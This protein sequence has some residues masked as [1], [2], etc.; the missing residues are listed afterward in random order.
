MRVNPKT[1][2][3]YGFRKD[4]NITFF[5]DKTKNRQRKKQAS[6]PTNALHK[7]NIKAIYELCKQL[8]KLTGVKHEVDHIVPLCGEYVSGLHVPWNLRVITREEN[9]KKSNKILS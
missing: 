9:A 7:S 8:T 2:L 6:A 1:N 5:P 4:C 3:P